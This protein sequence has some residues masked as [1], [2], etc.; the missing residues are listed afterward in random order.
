MA[1]D[2]C[3]LRG[4]EELEG[5]SCNGVSIETEKRGRFES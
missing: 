1:P 2:G 5:G 4:Q 3:F